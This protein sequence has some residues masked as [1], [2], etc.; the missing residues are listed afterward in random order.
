VSRSG[1]LFDDAKLR[2]GVP[3]SFQRTENSLLRATEFLDQIDKV[4]EFF[5][6]FV[7]KKQGLSFDFRV[8]FRVQPEQPGQEETGG[9]QIIVGSWTSG[10]EIC[11]SQR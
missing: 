11:V 8:Q 9:N 2:P 6:P 4:R 1:I 7:E 10:K 3:L 5:G